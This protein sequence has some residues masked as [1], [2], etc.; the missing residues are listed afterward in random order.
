M[1]CHP[2][3]TGQAINV[4]TAG[5]GVPFAKPLKQRNHMLVCMQ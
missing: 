4:S 1:H 2:S 5:L 3:F